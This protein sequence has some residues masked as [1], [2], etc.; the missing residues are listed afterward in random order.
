ML[1]VLPLAALT[2][3][4]LLATFTWMVLRGLLVPRSWV[5]KASADDAAEIAWLRQTNADQ[6]VTIG[7]LVTQNAELTVQGRLSVA[8]LQTLPTAPAASNHVGDPGSGHV[9]SIEKD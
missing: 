6:A 4:G 1:N 8:L 5:D 2:P 3:V 9:P 7:S